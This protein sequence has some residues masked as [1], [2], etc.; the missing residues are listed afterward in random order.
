MVLTSWLGQAKT[1][2]D[3]RW[4]AV[5]EDIAKA[6]YINECKAREMLIRSGGM[7]DHRLLANALGKRQPRPRMWG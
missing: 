4:A 1:A 7:L 3:V 5:R 2:V 6:K